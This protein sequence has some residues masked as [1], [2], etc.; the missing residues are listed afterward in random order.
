MADDSKETPKT[1]PDPVENTDVH[2]TEGFESE[3]VCADEPPADANHAPRHAAKP[4]KRKPNLK[5]PKVI[6]LIIVIVICLIAAIGGICFL[7]SQSMSVQKEE[8]QRAEVDAPLP[9]EPEEVLVEN[10]INFDEWQARNSDIYAFITYP[11]TAINHPILQNSEELDRYLKLDMDGEYSE[12]GEL[13]T[14]SLNSKDFDDPVTVIY[15]HTFPDT[16]V[17]FSDLH[18]LEDSAF[19]DANPVLYVYLPHKILTYEIISV[20]ETDNSHIL[21]DRDLDTA[22]GQQAYFDSILDPEWDWAY[23]KDGT[24]LKGGEDK[25]LQLSTCCIPSNAEKRYIVTAKLVNEQKTF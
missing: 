2:C 8:E 17:M 10:P 16:D 13:Y 14:Q 19:M 7:V 23:V 21:Y 3:Q 11:G 9:P 25:I 4:E 18:Y 15:G 24:T 5:D 6:A 22:E 20:A 12:Y 1:S